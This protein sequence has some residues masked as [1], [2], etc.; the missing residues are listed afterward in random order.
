MFSGRPAV[1]N[2]SSRGAVLNSD[3]ALHISNN[4]SEYPGRLPARYSHMNLDDRDDRVE[5]GQ[6]GLEEEQ[7]GLLGTDTERR[8]PVRTGRALDG[9]RAWA[10]GRW[11]VGGVPV[12]DVLIEQMIS[13]CVSS[14]DVML[15]KGALLCAL[16]VNRCFTL[17]HRE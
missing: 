17:N 15:R 4:G 10:D 13:T 5:L 12:S 1:G 9:R 2:S 7:A 8:Y 16:R 3:E 11:K 14:S 6:L